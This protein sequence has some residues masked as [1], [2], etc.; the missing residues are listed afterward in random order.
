M[1]RWAWTILA[2][3]A[4]CGSALATDVPEDQKAFTEVIDRFVRAYAEAQND[5][6]KGATRQQRAKAIC[7]AIKSPMVRDWIGTV[8]KLSSND[9]GKGVLGLTLSDH[10]WVKTYNNAFSDTGDHTLIDPESPVFAKA[11]ALKEHQRVRFSGSFLPDSKDCF[12]EGSMTLGGSMDEPEFLFRF[13][14]I[15]PAP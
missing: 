12:R 15:S 3:I 6:A 7:A 2:I 9:E 11:V 1:V 8:Y 4:S 14:D 10:L 5:M 13:S